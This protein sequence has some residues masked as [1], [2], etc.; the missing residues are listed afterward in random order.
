[1]RTFAKQDIPTLAYPLYL[2]ILPEL[3]H[4][5]TDSSFFP[6]PFHLLTSLL[7]CTAASPTAVTRTPASI[8][9]QPCTARI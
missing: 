8:T 6:F 7:T 2:Q 3:I 9:D 5:G 4:N 1:M